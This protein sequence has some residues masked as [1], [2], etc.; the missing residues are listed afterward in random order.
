VYTPE[1]FLVIIKIIIT[2]WLTEKLENIGEE[3]QQSI[4]MSIIDWDAE[5]VGFSDKRRLWTRCTHVYHVLNIVL[6]YTYTYAQQ[7]L[8]VSTYMNH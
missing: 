5:K 2:N 7:T 1:V 3:R 6:L 8:V 4:V